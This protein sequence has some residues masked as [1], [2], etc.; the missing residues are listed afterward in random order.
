MSQKR[1]KVQKIVNRGHFSKGHDPRRSKYKL[2]REDCQRG[3]QAALVKCNLD[4]DKA[5]WFMSLIRG[6]YR[7]RKRA[8]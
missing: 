7:A 2:T 5:A 3:Y 1:R 4:W 8:V 6:W